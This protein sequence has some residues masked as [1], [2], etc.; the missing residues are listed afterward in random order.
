MKFE[1]ILACAVGA[2]LLTLTAG[3][4]RA[5]VIDDEVVPVLDA[6]LIVKVTES[7]GKA[8]DISITSKDLVTAIGD[9]QDEDFSGDEI[10]LFEGDY[11]LVDKHGDEEEDLSE[12]G[13]ISYDH[14]ELTESEHDG[15]DSET[16][17]QTGVA[18]FTFASNAEDDGLTDPFDNEIY[19][20]QD[21]VPYSSTATER[22]I[23]RNGDKFTV[24]ITETGGVAT[25]GVD[26]NVEED[27]F[28]PVFGTITQDGSG[29][30]VIP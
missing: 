1:K 15:K 5:L 27:E 10:V 9:D 23:T 3:S 25:E 4:A 16:S 22:A 20:S 14:T 2:G 6:A 28:L 13:V 29:T 17:S 19:A 18:S 30:E 11:E 8:K 12:E 21:D 26:S 24:T 7:N